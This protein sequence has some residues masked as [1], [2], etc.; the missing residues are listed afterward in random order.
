MGADLGDHL[1]AVGAHGPITLEPGELDEVLVKLGAFRGVVHLGVELHRVK[2]ARGVGGDGKGRVGRGAVDLE[3]GRD[4]RH[5]VAVAHPDLLIPRLEP[6]RQERAGLVG[7]GDV[8]LA[9]FGGAVAAFDVAAQAMHHDLL[10]IA[11]AKDRHAQVKHALR[12]HRCAVPIDRGG[13][14]REDHGLGPEGP[15]E[16]VIHFV[17]GMNFAVNVQLAQATRDELRHLRAEIDDK[18]AVMLGHGFA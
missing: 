17:V 13:T 10:A 11:D 15:K 6:A 4:F 2:A 9:K 1:L 18:K 7:R 12:W 14:A 3:A 5:V 16:S 8:S